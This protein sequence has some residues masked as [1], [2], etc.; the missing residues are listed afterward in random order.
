MTDGLSN[1]DLV[2]DIHGHA[3]ALKELLSDMGYIRHGRG[4]RRQNRKVIFVGDFVD[5]GQDAS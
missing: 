5:Q 3:D 2:G 1:F 4:Y